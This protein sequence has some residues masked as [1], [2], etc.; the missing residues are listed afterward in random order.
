LEQATSASV[1]GPAF[2]RWFKKA[3]EEFDEA[4]LPA[5]ALVAGRGAPGSSAVV[6]PGEDEESA[7]IE[8]AR[9]ELAGLLDKVRGLAGQFRRRT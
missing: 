9:G 2:A 3:E 8:S 7:A 5:G 4:P 6:S 1:A